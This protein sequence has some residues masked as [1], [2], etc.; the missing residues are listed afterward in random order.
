[1]WEFIKVVQFDRLLQNSDMEYTLRAQFSITAAPTLE[2]K[3]K[4][5][6]QPLQN[7]K[8]SRFCAKAKSDWIKNLKKKL[9]NP[10]EIFETPMGV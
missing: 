3:G 8:I 2:R 9:H 7:L 5:A 1:M 4:E 6:Q 10:D